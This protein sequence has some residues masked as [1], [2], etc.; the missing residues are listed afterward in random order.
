MWGSYNFADMKHKEYWEIALCDLL[1][2]IRTETNFTQSELAKQ[3]N[4]PQSFVSKYEAGE[5]TLDVIE[6]FLICT[7][8]GVKFQDFAK[9]LEKRFQEITDES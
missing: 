7:I 1:R 6:V 9:R 5:R 8:L 4:K 2:E 3:L